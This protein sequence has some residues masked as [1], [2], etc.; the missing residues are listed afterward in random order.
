MV[1]LPPALAASLLVAL[2]PGG[3]ADGAGG[4]PTRALPGPEGRPLTIGLFVPTKGP[5]A[6]AGEEALR[7]AEIAAA[8]ANRTGGIRGRS[9]RLAT[10]SSDVPWSAATDAL[11][12]LIYDEDA[13]AIVGALD[14]RTGHLAEQVITRAKGQTVFV[15]PWVSETTLTRIGIPWFFQ[16]VPDDRRQGE[17]L[18]RE[19][20]R[21]RRL[22]RVAV[23]VEKGLD[24]ESAARAFLAHAPSGAVSPFDALS[25]GDRRDLLARA[26][27]GDFGAVILFTGAGAAVDLAR[28]LSRVPSAPVLLGPLSLA[29]PGLLGA[30]TENVADGMLLLAPAGIWSSPVAATFRRDY[31]KAHG[32]SPTPLAAYSH[33]AVKVLVEALRR[34]PSPERDNLA[35]TVAEIRAGGVT[36]EIRFDNH[37]GRDATPILARVSGSDLVPLAAALP[38]ARR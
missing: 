29:R 8:W 23:V 19:V 1:K 3:V 28:T 33:D 13:V 12:R 17:A 35:R 21:V 30:G 6:P 7:G 38:A 20:F 10:A 16:M 18:A 25:P 5:E 36:G 15:T 27:R 24:T 34:L 9:V 26:A 37:L 32:T 4:M 31:E 22:R 14:A 2:L 11:V